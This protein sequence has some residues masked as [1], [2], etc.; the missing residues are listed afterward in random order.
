VS[1]RFSYTQVLFL[2]GSLGCGAVFP[3]VSSP[4]RAPPPGYKLE[5]PPPADFY[6]VEFAGADIPLHTRDGRRWDEV[7]NAAPD[8]YAKLLVNDKEVIL[9]PVHADTLRPT[10]PDQE[11]ANYR[12]PANAN[13]RVELWDSNP[14]YS[15][16]ICT[17]KVP[18]LDRREFSDEEEYLSIE[19]DNGGRVRLV[20]KP[21]RGKF[22]LGLYYE[23]RTGDAYVTRVIPQSPAGRSGLR[24]G[25]QILRAQGQDVAKMESGKLQ[26]LINAN[27]SVGVQL[28]LK[29]EDGRVREVTLKDG[30]V[31]PLVSDGVEL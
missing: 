30:A 9:T 17:E 27:A 4:L 18:R 11:R 20:V 23:L 22:G 31:Y 3:E 24:P 16:P 28:T 2:L 29:G 25:D 8:P 15:H 13:V 10:W 5:P 7:G 6:Y 1:M 12:I 19:C 21:A 14:L 26:S